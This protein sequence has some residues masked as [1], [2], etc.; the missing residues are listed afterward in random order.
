VACGL[1]RMREPRPPLTLTEADRHG[2]VD[3]QTSCSRYLCSQVS[4]R[5]PT[6]RENAGQRD[7]GTTRDAI[8][9]L[10]L[11][12]EPGAPSGHRFR[13][14]GPLRPYWRPRRSQAWAASRQDARPTEPSFLDLRD[15]K[16]KWAVWTVSTQMKPHW[17]RPVLHSC[18][19][20]SRIAW[21]YFPENH[22]SPVINGSLQK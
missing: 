19:G 21:P 8:G 16:E 13:K 22:D 6:T 4:P 14:V 12:F 10:V 7:P 17:L 18:S 20:R 15:G 3:S 2:L 9:F 5:S 1:T 11:A